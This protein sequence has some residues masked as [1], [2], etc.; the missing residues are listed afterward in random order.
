M[1]DLKR[2]AGDLGLNAAAFDTCLDEGQFT[3]L[4]QEDLD[5][6]TRHG[7]SST[8]TIFINGRPIIGA[9]TFETFDRIVREELAATE[10][11]Q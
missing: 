6:G 1:E 5:Q 11:L 4:V 9:A 7:V 3:G 10:P 2:Y 8:P